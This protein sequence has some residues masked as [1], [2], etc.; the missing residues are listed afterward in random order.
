MWQVIITKRALTTRWILFFLYMIKVRLFA[1]GKSPNLSVVV[2]VIVCFVSPDW[3]TS[4]GGLLVLWTVT[5]FVLLRV[6][7]R[8]KKRQHWWWDLKSSNDS[9]RTQF[10]PSSFSFA[11]VRYTQSYIYFCTYM[12]QS[13]C[14]CTSGSAGIRCAGTKGAQGQRFQHPFWV[15]T[16]GNSNYFTQIVP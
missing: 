12:W 15:S 4:K 6:R 10:P 13:G 8:Y 3:V 7:T 16:C 14:G 11:Q 1:W 9:L 5:G 2:F